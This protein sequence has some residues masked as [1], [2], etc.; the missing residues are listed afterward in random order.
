M[1]E[2]FKVLKMMAVGMIKVMNMMPRFLIT[3]KIKEVSRGRKIGKI[4]CC[5]KQGRCLML[6]VP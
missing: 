6:T 4:Q 3:K 1:V 5:G 2:V